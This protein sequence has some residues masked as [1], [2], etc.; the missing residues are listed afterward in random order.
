M[1]P[2]F[3]LTARGNLTTLGELITFDDPNSRLPNVPKIF[4]LVDGTKQY[5]LQ[6][7]QQQRARVLDWCD[8]ETALLHF[9]VLSLPVA[10]YGAS[11]APRA[12][13]RGDGRDVAYFW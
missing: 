2:Q 11:G 10:R 13:Y 8:A 3:Y 1:Q 4:G 5:V 7:L 9:A 12:L 6:Q